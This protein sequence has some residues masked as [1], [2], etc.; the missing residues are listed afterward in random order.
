MRGSV[1][2]LSVDENPG[3]SSGPLGEDTG[4]SASA[5]SASAPPE[6]PSDVGADT[7]SKKISGLAVRSVDTE[8][9]AEGPTST[10][11]S[12]F[13]GC[14]RGICT[15]LTVILNPS[16][17]LSNEYCFVRKFPTPNGSAATQALFICSEA[18]SVSANS[19]VPSRSAS[20]PI[21]PLALNSPVSAAIPDIP[22]SK[23]ASKS[24]TLKVGTRYAIAAGTEKSK[25]K[26]PLKSIGL[27]GM[28]SCGLYSSAAVYA[29]AILKSALNF[30][31]TNSKLI[32]IPASNSTFAGGG[33]GGGDG[34]SGGGGG[35]DGSVSCIVPGGVN[36]CQPGAVTPDPG[37]VV[38]VLPSADTVAVP[39]MTKRPVV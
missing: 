13:G 10:R 22:N 34:G 39:S 16:S 18:E 12:V 11:K 38:I 1:P 29:S 30:N 21:N 4:R 33:F 20:V 7:L 2:I 24:C 25:V 36:P 8:T 28:V 37:S 19:I 3:I 17:I 5:A 26:L 15:P 23:S 31:G 9:F 6:V 14:V 32:P 27:G 35:G